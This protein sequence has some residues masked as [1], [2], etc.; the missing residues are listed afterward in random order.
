VTGIPVPQVVYGQVLQ[1]VQQMEDRIFDNPA[2]VAARHLYRERAD[3]YAR[4]IAQLPDSLS[5]E[6][7]ELSSRINELKASDAQVKDIVA[8]ERQRRELPQDPDQARLRWEAARSAA[9]ERAA[10]PVHHAAAFPT[11]RTGDGR[12]GSTSWR[13][14]SVSR[15]ARRRCRTC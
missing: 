11:V 6:R 8:L 14:Y 9:V 3:E 5:R 12:S 4:K 13:W 10:P 7:E 2:E 15:W 1:Q